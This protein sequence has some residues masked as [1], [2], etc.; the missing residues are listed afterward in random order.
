VVEQPAH[1]RYVASSIL[2]SANASAIPVMLPSRV[3]IAISLHRVFEPGERVVVAVSGGP[4]SL[5]LLSILREILPAL[6]LHLTV[7]H[8]DHGWRPDS[9]ADRDFVSSMAIEW[10]FDFHTAR[11]AGDVPHT[12]NAA[13][14]ARYAFLRETA[15]QT[16]S[17]AIALGH[18]QDDQV[19]TLLLHL[20][21]GSGSRGLSAM[22]RRDGDL[23]R[24]LLDVSRLDIEAYL[25]RLHLNPRRDSTNDDPRF[26]RNRLRQQLL[27]AIDVFEP[28]ARE[29]LARTADILSEE[30]R[31]LEDQVSRLPAEIAT[32]PEAFAKLAPA[33]QR[34]A[35]RRLIPEAGFAETE[36]RRRA[37]TSTN[38][39]KVVSFGLTAVDCHCDP[40]TFKARDEIGHLD[41]D[42]VRLPF[43]V[44]T[45]QPGDRMRPLGLQ[46]AKRLQ[47]ILVDAKVPRHLRDSLPVVSD[48]DEIVWI[49]GVTV[50]ETKRV[51]SSTRRQL[52]LE[53]ERR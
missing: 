35:I 40:A 10:G 49:P 15:R 32:N 45:R 17:T 16:A 6:P 51:T 46:A 20:L 22:R 48:G 12:E 41:A 50:S 27:P 19:E 44:R 28:S 9:E 18:T 25:Q 53:I 36:A 7:A 8:F 13:R 38:E 29:L 52:H 33:L 24:P 23:A 2:A 21:R 31:Y 26:S 3:A 47:D 42:R 34:R 39:P 4:D 14:S 37:G 30:D 5:A 1:T 43:S 11:A